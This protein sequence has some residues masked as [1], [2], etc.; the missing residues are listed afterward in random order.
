M[1]VVVIGLPGSGKS[2]VGRRLAARH[3]AAFVD[4]DVAIEK[5]AGAPIPAIFA[6]EGESGF[7]ARERAAI[8]A[9][10][11][12]DPATGISRVI[13][14]GGGAIV[15]PRNRWRLYRGRR[16]I[17]LDARPEVLAQRLRRSPNV[18][19]LIAGHDPMGAIRDLV[20]S[21]SRFYG[22]APRVNSIM[23]I[24]GVVDAADAATRLEPLAGTVLLRAAT[25]LGAIVIGEAML[26]TEVAAALRRLEGTRA[27]LISE[28]GAWE[29]AGAR[30]AADLEA[31]GLPVERVLLPGGEAAKTMAAV[32]TAAR[33]LARLRVERGEA[34][35]AIGGG[36]LT[37]AAGFLAATYLRG[38]PAIL[39]PTTLAGQIDAAIGGKSAIDLPEGKNLV[40]AFRQP[41][42]VVI[43]IAV[44]DAL[45]ERQRRAALGE[46]TKMAALGDERLFSLLE[47]DGPA[48]A[49][50]ERS[51]VE[52]GA[53][54]ELVERTA[55]AKVEIVLADEREAAGRISL[56]LGHSFAHGLEAASGYEGL[57]HGE[58]V[59]YGLRVAARIG[60]VRGVTPPE[61]AE[62]L[63]GLLDTLELGRDPLPFDIDAVLAAMAS[64]KKRRAG[65]L[66]WVLP[67][68]DGYVIDPEVPDAT[69]RTAGLGVL[70]GSPA[71][72]G[73]A[74]VE[75]RS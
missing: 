39:V 8:A 67:T 55:W 73:S 75:A 59:A 49:R 58:A 25:K 46:A 57:L 30:L 5:E 35:V 9:L 40:G 33:E 28:P 61:R 7:R 68:A 51:A 12:P 23:E 20:A 38:I 10:G 1:D 21:R 32:E 2:A 70:A 54:A 60:V 69:V 3:G 22:A 24:G 65:R 11:P 15:D 4:L 27:I 72:A 66:R 37:D 6:A 48:I 50:N 19:P 43:D 26:S 29:A 47:S 74:V 41:E 45:P 71:S 17:W 14:P 44:L 34:I 42:A 62:R 13:A 31:A 64:D 56:N 52:S 36:A 63:E 16:P 18:R 53:L